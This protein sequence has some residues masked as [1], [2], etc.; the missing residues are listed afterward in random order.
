MTYRDDREVLREQVA[1]LETR[2]EELVR[3]R[4]N[5]RKKI[6][7]FDFSRSREKASISLQEGKKERREELASWKSEAARARRRSWISNL[8]DKTKEFAF[9]MK[10]AFVFGAFALATYVIFA[11]FP[12]QPFVAGFVVGRHHRAAYTTTSTTCTGTGTS[13]TC[14][15]ETQSHPETWS[16]HVADD[17]RVQ[18]FS[19]SE[20][21]FNRSAMGSWYCA[22]ESDCPPIPRLDD[23][24]EE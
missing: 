15:T 17:T 20:D 2:V 1:S 16:L 8:F 11:H 12:T 3:E 22:Q 10:V 23:K 14:T 6:S 4:D 13:Q 21:T 19:V 18:A 5:L 9:E 7:D 24:Y